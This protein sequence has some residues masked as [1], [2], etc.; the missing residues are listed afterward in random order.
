ML[1]CAIQGGVFFQIIVLLTA[2]VMTIEWNNIITSANFSKIVDD[3]NIDE[4]KSL[5][6]SLKKANWWMI[7]G[8]IYVLLPCI[9]LLL[10]RSFADG[11]QLIIFLFLIVWSCDISAYFFGKLIGGPKLIPKISPN[12][13]YAGLFGAIF[14][15]AIIGFFTSFIIDFYSKTFFVLLSAVMVI[16]AQ[17]GDIF[18]SWL[19][20]RFDMKDS[21]N[22]IPGHGG[23][24]DRVDGLVTAS[25]FLLIVVILYSPV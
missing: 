16:V 11:L 19:K 25:V 8:I 22:I 1:F 12:K 17:A 4:E 15:S 18:E 20:R 9:S 23:I 6:S 24:L 3:P 2:I 13:T 10:L 7:T 14:V 5:L 21:S